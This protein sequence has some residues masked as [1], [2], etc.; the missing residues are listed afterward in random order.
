MKKKSS[1]A[2]LR[3]LLFMVF[4]SPNNTLEHPRTCPQVSEAVRWISLSSETLVST[5]V[6][7]QQT[8][9]AKCQIPG[10]GDLDRFCP[11]TSRFRLI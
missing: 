9:L 4:M 10:F 1:E 8:K 6:L 7:A 3:K 2:P 11:V 5:P